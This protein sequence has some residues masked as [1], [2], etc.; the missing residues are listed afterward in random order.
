[1]QTDSRRFAR[2]PHESHC[3][4]CPDPP[5]STFS[6][7]VSRGASGVNIWHL[8]VKGGQAAM[9]NM[10]VCAQCGVS[11]RINTWEVQQHCCGIFEPNRCEQS[12]SPTC[13]PPLIFGRTRTLHS[14]KVDV[15]CIVKWCQM[16]R[17]V[18]PAQYA[19]SIFSEIGRPKAHKALERK[20]QDTLC[21]Q[22]GPHQG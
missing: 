18:C 10:C 8:N 1:M 4:I 13:A 7:S 12:E 9:E 22:I 14:L 19:H 5:R 15:K 21:K 3:Y 11:L 2:M 16:C 17:Q 20:L 6:L